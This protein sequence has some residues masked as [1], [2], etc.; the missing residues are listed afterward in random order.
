MTLIY[1]IKHPNLTRNHTLTLFGREEVGGGEKE[2]F[3]LSFPSLLVHFI[4]KEKKG[5]KEK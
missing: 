1:Y 3:E 4:S 2:N 5:S